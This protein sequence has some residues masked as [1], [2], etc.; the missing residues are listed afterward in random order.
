MQCNPG[1][2]VDRFDIGVAIG[3][4]TIGQIIAIFVFWG[5][6]SSQS[7][8][9][10]FALAW[11]LF[12]GGFSATW[13]GYAPAMKRRNPSGHVDV[14]LVLALMAAGRGVGAVIS[15]PLSERLLEIGWKS[16]ASF[17]Y[18]TAYGILI[19][20]S[21]IAAAFGGTACVGRLLRLM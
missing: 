11:G 15:G 18:G 7:M 9:Y 3:V 20:F 12:G 16:H 2:L 14:G 21:G 17:A 5:L 1:L 6:T 19:I 10:V 4:V 13:S 8:L